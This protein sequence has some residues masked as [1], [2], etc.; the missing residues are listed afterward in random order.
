MSDKGQVQKQLKSPEGTDSILVAVNP[1]GSRL[2]VFRIGPATGAFTLYDSLTGEPL[3]TSDRE[4]G[5][6][7]A[8]V[9]SPDGTRVA[10]GGEDGLTR[11]WDTSTGKA[12]AV[13]RGHTRKVMSIAFRRDGLRL[14]TG[15]ADGTVR[16]WDSTTGREV[17]PAYDRHTGEVMTAKFSSDGVWI[18]SGGTDRTIRVWGAADRQDVAV[19]QGH[20]GDVRDLEFTA[21][22][23]TLVSASQM[24]TLGHLDQEDGTV[25]LWEIGQHGAASVLR[26]HTS[27]IYPVAFSPDGRWIASGSWD[28]TVRLWD[29]LTGETDAILTH[30]GNIRALAFSPDSSW[31]VS[32][33]FADPDFPHLGRCDRRLRTKLKCPG[34]VVA[35]TVAISGDGTQIA[36]SDFKGRATVIEAA[37][38]ASVDSFL[39][40]LADDK[41]SLSYSPDGRLLAGTGEDA[42]Q[43][44]IRDTRTRRRIAMLK[45]HAGVVFSVSFS[46]DG[47]LLASATR[48][49]RSAFGTWPR[50]NALPP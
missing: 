39:T 42:T 2:A 11:L 46:G 23:R 5:Y 40:G 3:A 7:Y 8:L 35:Q 41:K 29:A 26:G 45:G 44:D 1:E 38:G 37:T 10:T 34:H 16:Q 31:L 49:A 21:D 15:S 4:I 27:Y 48:I 36:A 9:F 22:G 20:T 43:I 17:A 30:P 19:L 33:C 28:N 18:A 25:R 32:A 6:A 50:R 24:P 13:C 14:A 47:R 12:T